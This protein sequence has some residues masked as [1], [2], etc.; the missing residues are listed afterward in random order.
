M[1]IKI[2]VDSS[3][4]LPK[5]LIDR[6]N[7][8]II[9]LSVHFGSEEYLDSIDITP[10]NFYKKLSEAVEMP[11]TSQ[12]P[13]ERFIEY[14]KR[15]LAAGNEIICITLGANAS[16]TCQ[17]AHIAKDEL[18]SE[19]I[20]IIDSNSLCMGIAYIAVEV[21]MM[22]EASVPIPEILEVIKPLTNNGV[23]HLFCV[24]TLEYLKK[25]GR[26]K[27]SKAVVAE[28][29]NIKPILNV[30]NAITQSIHKV[31]GRKKIIPYY[32]DKVKREIDMNS[33]QIM[34]AHSQDKE[35][36]NK[37]VE[38]LRVEL[39]WEKDIFI[40]EIGATIGTHTGPGVLA[41]FYK[42]SL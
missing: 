15:E 28:I 19:A 6:Y 2:I 37:L 7:F 30:E 9:P 21:A 32:I 10:E 23:E 27:A 34:V 39:P 38:A 40:S 22:V 14:F 25:G 33:N 36:A 18:E 26:I 41:C 12:I 1:S 3:S 17:S 35:F 5:E 8:K 20:T 16:G 11:T 24:D 42:K 4:D 13:P 29:L 31:R